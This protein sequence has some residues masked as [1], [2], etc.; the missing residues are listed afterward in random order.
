MSD[1]ASISAEIAEFA[2]AMPTGKIPASAGHI[3]RLSLL[4]WASVAIAGG[5]EPVSRKVQALVESEGGNAEATI[6]GSNTRAPARGAALANG[7][8]SHALDYDDTHFIHIGHTS[9]VVVSAA[10]AVAQKLGASGSDFLD[11][12]LI[13]VETACRIGDWLGRSHYQ[14]GFH[15][16]ATSGAFGAAMACAR[17]LGLDREK[18]QHALGIVS[19]RASGL[20]SQFGTMGKPYN[21]GIAASNG[22]EAALLAAAGFVSRP[23]GLECLQ[24][25]ADTHAAEYGD[26]ANALAG[27]GEAFT[28]ENVQHKFHACCHGLHASLEAL[29]VIRRNG[30]PEPDAIG[31]VMITTNPQ[32]LKVCNIAEPET[33]LEAKFSYRLTAAMAL[34]GINTGALTT[35]T[36]EICRDPALTALRDKVRVE[37]DENL[38]DTASRVTVNLQSGATLNGEYDLEQPLPAPIREAKVRKKSATLIGEEKSEAVW[39]TIEALHA[40]RL[41]TFTRFLTTA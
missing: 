28:F 41:S 39:Q 3:M 38:A 20:K 2:T 8:T 25:F 27:L 11:A 34:H 19:T 37:T 13:G 14:A 33:G 31:R 36:D 10:L 18:A 26:P 17:L 1:H 29:E 23:D 35:Y 40:S 9:V 21:A 6:V 4:D 30:R 15:Q 22:V 24:G 32:W 16:T 7:A 5:N 12:S